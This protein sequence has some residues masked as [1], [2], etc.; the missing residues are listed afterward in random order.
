MLPENETTMYRRTRY[1]AKNFETWQIILY[2][3]GKLK[4]K[5]RLKI[6]S[7]LAKQKPLFDGFFITQRGS[8]QILKI[9]IRYF[10]I[11]YLGIWKFRIRNYRIL[12]F[13]IRKFQIRKFWI[14]KFWIFFETFVAKKRS[15]S[16]INFV[17]SLC[18]T[19]RNKYT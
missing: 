8:T 1:H 9:I 12:D 18:I 17:Q 3:I 7:W 6:F 15:K 4:K 5:P 10:R 19:A 2:M 14:W 13:R 16:I 11:F